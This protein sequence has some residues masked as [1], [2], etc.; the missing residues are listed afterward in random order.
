MTA[1]SW[2]GGHRC[3][4]SFTQFKWLRKERKGRVGFS[5]ECV[6]WG[7]RSVGLSVLCSAIGFFGSFRSG[8]SLSNEGLPR[9]R[10]IQTCLSTWRSK[11]AWKHWNPAEGW[12]TKE[13]RAAAGRQS[14]PAE[15]RA[16]ACP[17]HLHKL[18]STSPLLTGHRSKQRITHSTPLVECERGGNERR[19]RAGGLVAVAAAAVE[20]ISHQ[21]TNGASLLLTT[22]KSG[23]AFF[24][25][26]EMTLATVSLSVCVR[27]NTH[28]EDKGADLLKICRWKNKHETA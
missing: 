2:G 21:V 15:I 16:E 6:K 11:K 25:G 24:W 3:F 28:L 18:S 17:C 4:D 14:A 27:A 23:D 8:R 1:Y 10:I 12:Q 9:T 7:R 13:R 26:G 20:F 5:S 22:S 19:T